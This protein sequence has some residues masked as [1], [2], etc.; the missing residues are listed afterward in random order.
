MLERR[1]GLE[2]GHV[3]QSACHRVVVVGL[4]FAASRLQHEEPLAAR[5]ADGSIEHRALAQAGLALHDC[6]RESRRTD[7]GRAQVVQP[8]PALVVRM[9]QAGG[10]AVVTVTLRQVPPHF[11]VELSGDVIEP[12]RLLRSS[13]MARLNERGGSAKSSLHCSKLGGQGR[14]GS[15]VP[16]G[17]GGYGQDR[18]A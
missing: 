14:V 10:V 1:R 7:E 16:R 11:V 4:E 3:E 6:R 12:G 17:R 9:P 18:V 15:A 5:G 2:A 8:L 13:R